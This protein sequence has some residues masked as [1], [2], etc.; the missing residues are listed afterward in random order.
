LSVGGYILVQG[1]VL[2]QIKGVKEPS[3]EINENKILTGL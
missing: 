2:T 3:I 1:M